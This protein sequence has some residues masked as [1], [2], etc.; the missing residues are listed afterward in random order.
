MQ[1][2]LTAFFCLVAMTVLGNPADDIKEKADKVTESAKKTANDAA[3]AISDAGE[4]VVDAVKP[5]EKSVLEKMTDG[6][7]S[8]GQ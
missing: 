8:I 5:K 2:N 6:V 3:K 4:S 7:K 1:S